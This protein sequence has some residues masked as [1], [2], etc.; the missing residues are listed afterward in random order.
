MKKLKKCNQYCNAPCHGHSKVLEFQW[1]ENESVSL[2]IVQME[3]A[4][5]RNQRQLLKGV[6]L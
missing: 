3:Y 2:G 1:I 4:L 6:R 5:V